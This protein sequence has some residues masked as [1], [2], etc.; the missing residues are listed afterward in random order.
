MFL[1]RGGFLI[2]IPPAMNLYM[3]GNTG[4]SQ[5]FGVKLLSDRKKIKYPIN[6]TAIFDT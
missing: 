2:Y 6:K 3:P 5:I 1:N 4:V